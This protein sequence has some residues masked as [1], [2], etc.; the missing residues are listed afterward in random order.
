MK[1]RTF[2]R[3]LEKMKSLVLK[4]YPANVEGHLS[5]M[6]AGE[7]DLALE[8]SVFFQDS[9]SIPELVISPLPPAIITHVGPGSLAVGFFA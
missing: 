2:Y 1:E 9:L 4:E 8:L 7:P 5:I 6:H 3:A